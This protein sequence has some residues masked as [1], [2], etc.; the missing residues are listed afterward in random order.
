[1]PSIPTDRGRELFGSDPESYD[2]ARP[3][4]PDALYALLRPMPPGEVLEVGAGSGIATRRLLAM[5]SGRLVVL[6]PDGRFGPMLDALSAEHDGRLIVVQQ[7]LETAR[8]GR[9]SFDLVLVAT[10][11]HWLNPNDR[12]ARLWDLTKPGGRLALFWNVFQIVGTDDPFH[13]ATAPLLRG[14]ADTPSATVDGVPFALRRQERELELGR[15]GFELADYREIRWTLELDPASV[16]RLY[17]TFPSIQILEPPG[18]QAVL[19]ALERISTNEFGGRVTRNMTSVG[20]LFE[21]PAGQTVRAGSA[22]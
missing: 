3:D 17:S 9:H 19:D 20:Y 8:L 2:D 7:P 16:R 10:A 15:V 12:A 5:M 11:F 14:L 13:E 21:K 1:M 4:Y 22:P 6:E 18:R